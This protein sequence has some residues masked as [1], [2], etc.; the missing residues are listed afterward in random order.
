MAWELVAP[1]AAAVASIAVGVGG[2]FF[3]WLT[4]RQGREHAEAV[5]G[6]QLAHERLLA[7]EARDQQRL[8]RPTSICSVCPFAA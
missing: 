3:T 7:S 2:V 8:E 1:V 6:Q 5:L 4:G